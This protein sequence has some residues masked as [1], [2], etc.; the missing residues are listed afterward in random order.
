MITAGRRELQRPEPLRPRFIAPSNVFT[1]IRRETA[2]AGR[3]KITVRS[4]DAGAFTAIAE[5]N[6]TGQVNG[7]RKAGPRRTA[8]YARTKTRVSG[9][10]TAILKLR[11]TASA[12]RALKAEKSLRVE[13]RIT[14]A[15]RGG[16]VATKTLTVTVR[17][18]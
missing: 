13:V 8:T 4:P 3:V 15:P 12:T 18:R 1:V 5:T 9:A 11:P 14:F 6:V 16:K 10:S 2:L 7:R 17:R